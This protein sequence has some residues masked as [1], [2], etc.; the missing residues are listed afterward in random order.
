MSDPLTYAN[1]LSNY[2]KSNPVP[3]DVSAIQYILGESHDGNLGPGVS[4]STIYSNFYNQGLDPTTYVSE[5]VLGHSSAALNPYILP[6]DRYSLPILNEKS[7]KN[8][9]CFDASGKSHNLSSIIDNVEKTAILK[10]SS[11]QG[12][13]YSLYASLQDYNNGISNIDISKNSYLCKP[14]TAY[15]DDTGKKKSTPIYVLKSDTEGF[16][17]NSAYQDVSATFLNMPGSTPG[18]NTPG[19]NSPSPSG[20][21]ILKKDSFGFPIY[22][23]PD[24]SGLPP[25]FNNLNSPSIQINRELMEQLLPPPGTTAG[26]KLLEETQ[27][28]LVPTIPLANVSGFTTIE[29]SDI[30]LQQY[31]NRNKNPWSDPIFLFYVGSLGLLFGCLIYRLIQVKKR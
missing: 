31:Q 6:G 25:R 26:K 1:T 21:E 12:L 18:L 24:G 3:T 29:S 11:N 23:T 27:K 17:D 16:I 2:I 8:K 20:S 4:P 19:P 9:Q 5:F 14:V 15:M 30:I 28:L 7:G 10:D 22:N 13:F